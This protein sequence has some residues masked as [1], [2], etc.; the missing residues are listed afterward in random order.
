[1]K[2]NEMKANQTERNAMKQKELKWK[3]V[4]Q[5][6]DEFKKSGKLLDKLSSFTFKC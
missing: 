2:W 3:N 5:E 6:D 1:M 4:L